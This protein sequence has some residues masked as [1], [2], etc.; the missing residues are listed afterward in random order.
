[1]ATK[2]VEIVAGHLLT[3]CPA[4]AG[5]VSESA[6]QEQTSKADSQI[7]EM[8]AFWDKAV[9]K[10]LANPYKYQSVGVLII[11]WAEHLDRQLNCGPEVGRIRS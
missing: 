10:E 4:V 1:M 7:A 9:C 11:R 2:D 8:Q 5:E 3:R 6:S